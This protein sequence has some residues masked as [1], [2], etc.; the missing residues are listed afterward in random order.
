VLEH[1]EI[2]M[3]HD[4]HREGLSI[5]AIARRTGLSRKTIRK[6]L[7]RGFVA[8]V[9]GPRSPRG[10]ALDSYKSYLEGRLTSYPE[11]TAIRL[12]REIAQL[13]YSGGYTTDV[14]PGFVQ[15]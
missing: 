7:A 13:R 9:S 2:F 1:G 11:L 10:S 8:P 4:L 12:K 5:R 3:I 15:L 6:Y 14:P